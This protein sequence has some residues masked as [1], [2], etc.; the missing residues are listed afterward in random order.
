MSQF[1]L[2]VSVIV[3]HEDVI[4]QLEDDVQKTEISLGVKGSSFSC[5][6]FP[7]VVHIKIQVRV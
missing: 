7:Q 5:G 2:L 1:S 3:P 6:N 4:S